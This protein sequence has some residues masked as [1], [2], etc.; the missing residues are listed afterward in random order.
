GGWLA[1][2][3][4]CVG[5]AGHGRAGAGFLSFSSRRRHTSFKCDWSSDVCS[6]DL[7]TGVWPLLLVVNGVSLT[8]FPSAYRTLSV[9]ETLGRLRSEER[10]VGKECRSRGAADH[11]EARVRRGGQVERERTNLLL[12][13][14]HVLP[15]T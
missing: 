1:R 10:R 5:C 13:S 12:P 15:D 3:D 8:T 7:L 14:R 4:R 9:G 2:A 11:D 6:S